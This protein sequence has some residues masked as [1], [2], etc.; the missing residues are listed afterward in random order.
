MLADLPVDETVGDELE[1]LD[2][3]RRRVRAGLARRRWAERDDRAAAT[4]ATTRCSRLEAATVVAIAVQ[5][6]LTLG[7]VHVMGIGFQVEAL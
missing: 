4:R 6:L 5:D 1:Y 3:A 2:L 7:G